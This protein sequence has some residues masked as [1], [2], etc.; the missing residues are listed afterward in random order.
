VLFGTDRGR[1]RQ[2]IR[3]IGELVGEQDL[4]IPKRTAFGPRSEGVFRKVE[5][6]SFGYDQLWRVTLRRGKQV[7][8]VDATRDHRWLSSSRSSCR[9]SLVAGTTATSTSRPR[10]L[11]H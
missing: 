10:G 4:L 9:R 3:P 5:V 7:K 6:R 1:D 11:A 8:T 2:G